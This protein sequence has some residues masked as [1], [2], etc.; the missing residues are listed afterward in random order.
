MAG[1]LS[2]ADEA[3]TAR[4]AY[5]ILVLVLLLLAGR[6]FSVQVLQHRKFLRLALENQFKSKRVVA[7]RGVI[8]DRSGKPL[9][10]MPALITD[11][12]VDAMTI[13]GK[14]ADALP[15]PRQSISQRRPV[16]SAG[17]GE[18]RQAEGFLYITESPSSQT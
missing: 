1:R 11:E 18:K 6:L 4:Y 9:G 17:D 13:L 15:A 14:M 2:H 8:R 7:P 10:A 3:R 16:R 12:M 5:G